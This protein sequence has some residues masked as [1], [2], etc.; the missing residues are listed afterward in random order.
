MTLFK[1]RKVKKKNLRI[2]AIP[3][4]H[5]QTLT[6]TPAKFQRDPAKTVGGVT[7]TRLD[8]ICDGPSDGRT[9]VRGIQQV[10]K[11][12]KPQTQVSI[13]CCMCLFNPFFH[14]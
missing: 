12:I 4:A 8:A 3:H 13:D 11:K 5:P 7:F 1:L 14:E 9:D 10:W 6:K 2:T